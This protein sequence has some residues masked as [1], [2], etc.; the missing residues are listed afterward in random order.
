[1]DYEYKLTVGEGENAIDYIIAD[2]IPIDNQIFFTILNLVSFE[3]MF[4]EY[5][6][7]MLDDKEK[8]LAAIHQDFLDGCKHIT[9][10]DGY[11]EDMLYE[12]ME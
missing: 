10:V 1:M 5:L 3:V 2:V 11:M 12:M 9:F 4:G 8:M 7:K 6:G